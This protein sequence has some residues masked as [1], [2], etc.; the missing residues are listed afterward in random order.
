MKTSLFL[1]QRKFRFSL[2]A[3]LLV[4]PQTLTLAQELSPVRQLGQA[5]A[6]NPYQLTP[7][8]GVRPRER[9]LAGNTIAGSSA[10]GSRE[11]TSELSP[12]FEGMSDLAEQSIKSSAWGLHYGITT[13]Y[14]YDD[15][16]TLGRPT[17]F[18]PGGYSEGDTSIVSVS[19]YAV[20]TYGEPG[21][22]VD[23]QLR[24]SPE[25]R[26]YSN[27]NLDPSLN[28]TLSADL[29]INGT[30]SR[31]TVGLSYS[32]TE[33]ANIE[34]GDLVTADLIG[35]QIGA[36]YDISDK[37]SVGATVS[38]QISEYDIFN[39]FSIFGVGLYADYAVTPKTRL[40]LGVGYDHTEQKRNQAA[41]AFNLNLR[42]N[43]AA[44]AKMGVF[45][46]F[47]VEQREYEG[48]ASTTSPIF[49]L[50][51][52]YNP[53]DKAALQLAAYRKALPSIGINDGMYY[54]TGVAVTGTYLVTSKISANLSIGFENSEYDSTVSDVAVDRE[55]NY[56]FIRPTINYWISEHL[57]LSLFYQYSNN[58]SSGLSRNSITSGTTPLTNSYERNQFG[59]SLTLAY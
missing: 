41:D 49:R 37:T 45:G 18:P 23:F 33:G 30:R 52:S 21:H 54:G 2:A 27:E 19:P 5:T 10:V 44:T 22:G 7:E 28:H 40:G 43:W 1:I 6:T 17:I 14:E 32:H 48:G 56:F 53:T 47:G 46:S 58:D 3:L 9:E 12:W 26:W 57:S 42:L 13:S 55:D 20:L 34:V 35:L 8:G 4:L 11:S 24:Y 51:I 38:T 31:V 50:G 59:V 36:S 25:Y 39:S 29:G 16:F 15:N